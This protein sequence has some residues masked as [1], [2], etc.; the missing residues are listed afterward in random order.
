MADETGAPETNGFDI[1]PDN[2]AVHKSIWHDVYFTSQDGFRLYA[3]DYPKVGGGGHVPILC[4][5]GLTRNSKDFADF[6]A[7]H[8]PRRRIVA[9]DYRG[10][11]RSAYCKDWTLYSPLQEMKDVIT[12]LTV[13]G[14]HRVIVL[15]TSRGGLIARFRTLTPPIVP[16][17]GVDA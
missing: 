5:A 3:R 13:L 9:M 14:I 8:A 15:G 12:L 6:A 10:R 2:P 17:S 1:G 16:E 11:G 4:L 7:R